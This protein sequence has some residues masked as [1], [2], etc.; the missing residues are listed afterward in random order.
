[1]PWVVEDKEGTC[2][3]TAGSKA[4][5]Q[6]ADTMWN[7]SEAYYKWFYISPVCLNKR[8]KYM[9]KAFCYPHLQDFY[10]AK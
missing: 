2:L 4:D 1:V 7:F 6:T 5:I 9:N 10:M 8:W 3:W